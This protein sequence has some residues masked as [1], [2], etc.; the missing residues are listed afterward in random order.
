MF[1]QDA[2]KCSIEAWKI[3]MVFLLCL[4]L[5]YM[6]Y[7][8]LWLFL[9]SFRF[10]Y[11]F[12]NRIVWKFRC[13]IFWLVKVNR[14]R[15]L[16]LDHYLCSKTINF[17]WCMTRPDGG[18]KSNIESTHPSQALNTNKNNTQICLSKHICHNLHGVWKSKKM[19]HL[20]HCER[21]ELRLHFDWTKVDSKCQKC[22]ILVSFLK[23]WNLMSNSGTRQVNFNRS[24]IGGN[25]QNWKI[26]IRHLH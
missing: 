5:S 6:F 26:P 21:S 22:C 18:E 12:W 2:W 15:F 16:F 9:R 24:K 10:M 14:T 7:A 3:L 17:S 11:Y 25:C 8:F 1:V 19:S 23:T 20:K 4:W 13:N